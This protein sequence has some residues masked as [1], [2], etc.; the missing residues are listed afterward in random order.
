MRLEDLFPCFGI[1][2]LKFYDFYE[3]SLPLLK[4]DSVSLGHLA[5]NVH[6]P[7][8]HRLSKNYYKI[9]GKQIIFQKVELNDSNFESIYIYI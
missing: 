2:N 9:Y 5:V 3:K 1:L 6:L 8:I 7:T 4:F